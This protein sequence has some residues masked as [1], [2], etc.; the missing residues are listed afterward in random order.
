MYQNYLNIKHVDT[1]VLYALKIK[2]DVNTDKF[3]K[4]Y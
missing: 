1:N 2:I 3:Y 4:L